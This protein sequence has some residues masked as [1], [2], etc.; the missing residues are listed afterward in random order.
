MKMSIE[1]LEGMKIYIRFP[2]YTFPISVLQQRVGHLDSQFFSL[3]GFNIKRTDTELKLLKTF[4][5]FVA[6]YQ[7]NFGAVLFQKHHIVNAKGFRRSKLCNY[8][9]SG[10]L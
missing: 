8:L 3:H 7:L 5:E 10:K 9:R 1:K 4:E 6:D 2:T